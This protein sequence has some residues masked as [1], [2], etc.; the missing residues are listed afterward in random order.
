MLISSCHI[1]ER[2]LVFP[3]SKSLVAL[4]LSSLAP[5]SFK[6]AH[7]EVFSDLVNFLVP[8]RYLM[9]RLCVLGVEYD[10]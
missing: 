2:T 1:E 4:E 5:C 10:T 8:I 3:N 7:L 9:L 6:L